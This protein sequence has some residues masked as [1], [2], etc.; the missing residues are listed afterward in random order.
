MESKLILGTVQFGLDYGINNNTGII[1]EKKIK[2]ILDYAF[3]NGIKLLDTAEAYGSSQKK[4]GEYHKKSRN[5]FGVITKFSSKTNSKSIDIIKRI[6]TNLKILNV[7]KLYCYM[8]HSFKEFDTSFQTYR[9]DLLQ[10]RKNGVIN[11]IGVSI[12]TNDEFEKVLRF[13]DITLVQLPFNLLDN[14]N[15]RGSI[16]KKAKEKGI[17]IHTRSV[18]LQG[19]FFKNL[20]KL[21]S[22]TKALSGYLNYLHDFCDEDY[23]IND[24]ALNYVYNK[25]N[26]DKVLIGVD[27]I[28]HLKLNLNSVKKRIK[29]KLIKEIENVN[30]K[31]N[32]LLNPSNW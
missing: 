4:I 15:K 1:S 7:N 31:E 25:K 23:N 11:R 3:N 27:N 21:P 19:L 29:N 32:N 2:E 8:F 22:K 18:F 24:L 6:Q 20:N 28:L 14:D 13:K 30:V 9:K 10:L 26:I 12:Y 16:I 17:E 5:K